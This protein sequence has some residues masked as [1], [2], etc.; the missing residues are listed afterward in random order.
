MTEQPRKRRKRRNFSDEFKREAV[1]LLRSSNATAAEVGRELGIGQQL[2][3]R[4]AKERDGDGPEAAEDRPSYDDLV[5][6]NRR[7]RMEVDFLKKASS[8]FASRQ[9]TGI[10]R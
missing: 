2:L 4:W 9:P 3:S 6:E 10:G 1:E 5:R 7:L 8:Y